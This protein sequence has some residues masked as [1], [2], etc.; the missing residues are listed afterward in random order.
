MNEYPKFKT[1]EL[2]TEIQSSEGGQD[3]DLREAERVTLIKELKVRFAIKIAVMAIFTAIGSAIIF[4]YVWH[5]LSPSKW[6]W[7]L[8]N[9]LARIK[10]L[11]LSIA[12]GVVLSLATK[13]TIK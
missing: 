7:L 1:K 6:H 4:T 13:F 5:L 2:K 11:A 9:E 10:D 3:P 12:T 8:P